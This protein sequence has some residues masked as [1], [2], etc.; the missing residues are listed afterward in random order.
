MMRRLLVLHGALALVATAC[1]GTEAAETSQATA[2]TTL[3]PT[4]ATTTAPTPTTAPPTT[5]AIPTTTV[6]PSTAPPAGGEASPLVIAAVDFDAGVVEIRNDGDTAYDATGHW[7]C[8]RPNYVPLPEGVI[9]PGASVTITTSSIDAAPEDG[10]VGLYTAR[11]FSN[12]DA[13]IRYL[14]WGS[15]DHGRAAVAV[16]AGLWPEG[17]FVANGGASMLAVGSNP[18]SSGDWSAAD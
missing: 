13:M 15:A 8:N 7:V 1:G 12:A 16:A 14:Q 10:E 5:V 18:V 9:E 3:P 4:T 17:D 6:P 2:A 11:E